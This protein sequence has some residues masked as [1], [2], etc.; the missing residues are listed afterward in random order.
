MRR[1]RGGGSEGSEN[2]RV[3]EKGVGEGGMK[4]REGGGEGG[5]GE[6]KGEGKQT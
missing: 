5:E 4:G 1:V 3:E 6:E 2:K